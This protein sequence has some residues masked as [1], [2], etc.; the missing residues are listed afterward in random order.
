MCKVEIC[1]ACISQH[2]TQLEIDTPQVMQ[3]ESIYFDIDSSKLCCSR[4][5]LRS[6]ICKLSSDRLDMAQT[7]LCELLASLSVKSNFTQTIEPR[8]IRSTKA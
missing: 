4:Y 7:I 2:K 3:Y 6:L 8:M 5:P 1:K